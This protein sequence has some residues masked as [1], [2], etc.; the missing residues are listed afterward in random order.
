MDEWYTPIPGTG[1]ARLA[2]R[3]GVWSLLS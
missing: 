2:V 3:A 1:R